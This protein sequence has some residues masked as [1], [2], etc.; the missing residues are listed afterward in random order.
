MRPSFTENMGVSREL[1]THLIPS[2][3]REEKIARKNRILSVVLPGSQRAPGM[4]LA[5]MPLLPPGLQRKRVKSIGLGGTSFCSCCLLQLETSELD[6]LEKKQG[7]PEFEC[8]AVSVQRRKAHILL[9][10]VTF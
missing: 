2:S 8:R 9:P 4:A 10:L 7:S 1:G 3:D 6:A 5:C